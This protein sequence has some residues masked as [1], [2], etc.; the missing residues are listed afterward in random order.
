[1][2]ALD[3]TRLMLLKSGNW[4]RRWL[5]LLCYVSSLFIFKF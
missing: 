3:T 5:L 2:K 4:C 1:M